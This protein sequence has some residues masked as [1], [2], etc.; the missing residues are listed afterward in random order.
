[1]R[2][3]IV[4]APPPLESYFNH[5]LYI[6]T[7]FT[8]YFFALDVI[9]QYY[10]LYLTNFCQLCKDAWEIIWVQTSVSWCSLDCYV[11]VT[12]Q[13]SRSSWAESASE[14]WEEAIPRPDVEGSVRPR[15][16]DEEV[17]ARDAGTTVEFYLMP[18]MQFMSL[19]FNDMIDWSRS[20]NK[21]W[22]SYKAA[23]S[24]RLIGL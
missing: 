12:H 6:F 17:W 22:S 24:A 5:W 18:V 11:D 1:V 15:P 16:A 7:F 10:S 19:Y 9:L 13:E 4:W 20:E 23:A 8:F 3:R 14:D 2:F 21:L